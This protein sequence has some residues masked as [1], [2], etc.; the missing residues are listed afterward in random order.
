MRERKADICLCRTHKTKIEIAE[1]RWE[2]EHV[3]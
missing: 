1:N 2:L 3:I